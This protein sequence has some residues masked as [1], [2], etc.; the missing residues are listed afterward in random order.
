[1]PENDQAESRLDH[2]H[3][4]ESVEDG[5]SSLVTAAFRS[6]AFV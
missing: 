2:E 4:R 6:A 5:F 3:D 1:M